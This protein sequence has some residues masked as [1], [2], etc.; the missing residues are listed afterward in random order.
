MDLPRKQVYH[1]T[2][3]FPEDS[4]ANIIETQLAY[5]LRKPGMDMQPGLGIGH[6]LAGIFEINK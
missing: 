1:G 6:G 2:G 4:Q 3:T 5:A